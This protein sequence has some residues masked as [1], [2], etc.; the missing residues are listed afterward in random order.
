[1]NEMVHS[2]FS[3][4][5]A[6]YFIHQNKNNFTEAKRICEQRQM[7]LVRIMTKEKYTEVVNFARL[8]LFQMYLRDKPNHPYN[9]WWDRSDFWTKMVLTTEKPEVSYNVSIFNISQLY[10]VFGTVTSL[11]QLYRV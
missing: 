2:N 10:A 7:K 11:Y 8:W 3:Q 5:S 9:L 4:L 1:M 6:Q